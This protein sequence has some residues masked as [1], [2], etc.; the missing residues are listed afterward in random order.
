MRS[1][2]KGPSN[3]AERSLDPRSRVHA[4]SHCPP[5]VLAPWKIFLGF[6]QVADPQLSDIPGSHQRNRAEGRHRAAQHDWGGAL[7]AVD[8]TLRSPRA[9]T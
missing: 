9:T 5:S 4:T 7:F 3:F 8:S 2:P 6:S 1:V